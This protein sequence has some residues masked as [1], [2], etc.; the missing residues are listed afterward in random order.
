MKEIDIKK[1]ALPPKAPRE[2]PSIHDVKDDSLKLKWQPAEL[3]PYA[4]PT[5]IY[6]IVER[7]CPPSKSWIEVGTD[8]KTCE[9]TMKNYKPEKD[10]M[11]R[12]RA[13]NDYGIS[14]PSM[15]NTIFAKGWELSYY[16]KFVFSE[17]DLFWNSCCFVIIVIHRYNQGLPLKFTI[18]P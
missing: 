12:I 9:F 18:Q 17:N 8:L 11:F 7:R 6:Y 5:P 15:T 10:Y 2:K 4:L 3:P 16:M 1:E 14:D 13:A